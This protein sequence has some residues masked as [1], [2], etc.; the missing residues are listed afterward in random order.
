M[1]R[2]SCIIKKN[3]IIFLYGPDTFRSRVHLHRI[4][5]KFKKDRD[6]QGLNVM[7]LDA[8]T[9][10]KTVNILQEVLAVPFLADRRMIVLDGLLTAKKKEVQAE[11]LKRIEEKRLPDSN[12]I[13]FWEGGDVPKAS[14]AKAL[15]EHLTQ[16]K[17]AQ[18][19]DLLT[20]AALGGWILEEIAE[21][22]GKMEQ[23]AVQFLVAHTDGDMWRLHTLLD[24]F[25]AYANDRPITVDDVGL[26]LEEK[27]DD[28][29]FTLVDALMARQGKQ[30]YS[31][32]G[33]QYRQGKDALYILTMIARQCR[34]FLQIRDLFDRFPETTSDT[35]AKM[36]KLHPFVVKKSLGAVKRTTKAELAT[37][38]EELLELD[39]A[40][41]TGVAASP[42]L[43]DLWIGKYLSKT[44]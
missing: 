33:E 17:F 4:I 1:L 16:E 5:A 2:A 42:V 20:G 25:R 28:N 39:A 32:L 35:A 3:M 27:I 15:Y 6:P 29:I 30:V 41:K 23:A 24:Q 36:L 14:D 8:A 22:G 26:F 44:K 9:D 7:R 21:R 34:I 13:V 19:F 40:I 18:K 10:E 11:L 38:H 12:V 31:L 43:L 37:W